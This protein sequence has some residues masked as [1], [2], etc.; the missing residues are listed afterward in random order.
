MTRIEINRLMKKLIFTVKINC[1]KPIPLLSAGPKHLLLSVN[2]RFTKK[3]KSLI[4]GLVHAGW[5]LPISAMAFTAH[6]IPGQSTPLPPP[7]VYACTM[8]I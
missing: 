5:L 8:K 1:T 4:R 6:S 3:S 2:L 7:A